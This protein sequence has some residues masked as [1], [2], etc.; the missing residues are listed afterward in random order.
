VGLPITHL[1]RHASTL[2]V[3]AFAFAAACSSD[4]AGELRRSQLSE[5]CLIN[6]D[7]KS[8]LVCAFR[9]CHV[10][11]EDS[12][13]CDPQQLCIDADK[14]FRVCQ[15]DIERDCEYN[16]QCPGDQVCAVDA[17]CRDQCAA[18]KDCGFQQVCTQG[19]CAEAWELVDGKLPNA[20]PKNDGG[21]PCT[22]NSEC[23][24]PQ[25]CHQNVC[26]I[27]CLETV[28]CAAGLECI[29]SRCAVPGTSTDGGVQT[30]AYNSD[31]PPKQICANGQC[32]CECKTAVD[33]S[34]GKLCDGCG[35]VSDKPDGAPPGYGEPCSLPSDCDSGLV[36]KNGSC[37]Y[38]CNASID[39]ATGLCCFDH[40]CTTGAVCNPDGGPDS[41]GFE[42]GAPCAKNLDCDDGLW[43]NGPEQCTAG[44]CAPALDT[45]CNSHS[46][47]IQ[48]TCTEATKQCSSVA[49][50]PQDGDGDTY[51]DFGCGGMDCDDSNPSM[52]PGAPEVCDLE[53]ND[54][55]GKVD[56]KTRG[57]YGPQY[58][59]TAATATTGAAV[60]NG[61]GF[62]AFYDDPATKSVLARSYDAA[63][64]PTGSATPV[65][66]VSTLST[67]VVGADTGGGTIL[68]LAREQVTS[69]TFHARAVVLKTDL[70]PVTSLDLGVLAGPT[71]DVVWT[72]SDYL[73]AWAAPTFATH[74]AHVSTIGALSGDVSPS[75][76]GYPNSSYKTFAASAGASFGL[77]YTSASSAIASASIYGASGSLLA[78]PITP[79]G[80]AFLAGFGATSNGG[81]IL[82]R[83]LGGSTPVANHA[84][85]QGVLGPNLTLPF[86]VAPDAADSASDGSGAMI[87]FADPS[88][89]PTL[90]YVA[91]DGSN[92]VESTQA[93]TP[94]NSMGMVNLA[95]G[96]SSFVFSHFDATAHK[97]RW[98]R[99][100]CQ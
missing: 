6:T 58:V 78:G 77:G 83:T 20:Q 39:C 28:D 52:Y 95:G 8:P 85:A 26:R 68:L 96:P 86:T 47:C 53:D 49:L 67:S 40:Q 75:I 37:L 55:N 43:C 21:Q 48:D 2:G 38:E 80:N 32:K 76:A 45:P 16:S 100:G 19:T 4:E 10:Q 71:A 3:L 24:P 46:S 62:T 29:A 54:C 98:V 15:L 94:D 63:G 18:D 82:L 74:L 14:P 44:K 42:G 25:V 41:G 64:L 17:H 79:S 61:T 33:C 93:L 88:A 60:P 50:A 13:D 12:R 30:C 59:L 5:G 51:L 22:Y 73:L 65:F 87:G 90:M 1:V 91:G 99:A 72:G 66:T 23:P 27:E 35:C 69:G 31:C 84:T 7:C 11:C 92:G 36:C 56:D 9:R 57:P 97:L 89:A 81:F 70:S 34:G